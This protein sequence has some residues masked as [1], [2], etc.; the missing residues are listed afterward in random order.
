MGPHSTQPKTQAPNG[1]VGLS[2]AFVGSDSIC[3]KR[4]PFILNSLPAKLPLQCSPP[5]KHN[6]VYHRAQVACMI[7]KKTSLHSPVTK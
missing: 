6:M 4:L 1:I 5:P 3:R 2:K 7:M